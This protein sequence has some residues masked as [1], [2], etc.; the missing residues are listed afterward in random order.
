VRLTNLVA[1]TRYNTIEERCSYFCNHYLFFYRSLPLHPGFRAIQYRSKTTKTQSH[2]TS[3]HTVESPKMTASSRM[4]K[5][6]VSEAT[7][8]AI[9]S[10]TTVVPRAF[11]K[12]NAFHRAAV[13]DTQAVREWYARIYADEINDPACH[14]L[15][16]IDDGEQKD[17]SEER[18][19]A[20]GVLLLRLMDPKDKS[21][22]IWTKHAITPDHDR[23]KYEA[24][25]VP[26]GEMR[27][28]IMGD[29]EN[30]LLELFGVDDEA[31]GTG[32]GRKL[33]QRACEISDQKGVD[34]FVEGNM[35]AVEFYRKFGFEVVKEI[36]LPGEEE[37]REAML[38]RSAGGGRR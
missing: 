1:T 38:V 33:L 35:F 23:E 8:A 21:S 17:S 15:T 10:L 3:I 19:R 16:V 36:V 9:P 4:S 20:L 32:L 6:E 2:Q 34:I 30:F 7:S 22:G 18:P 26:M 24:M 11:H 12:T 5:L 13:P 31:K 27:A 37:Y 25:V 14:V 28:E 29:R